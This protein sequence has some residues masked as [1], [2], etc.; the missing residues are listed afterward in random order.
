[1]SGR[2]ELDSVLETIMAAKREELGEPPTPEEL[3]AYRDGELDPAARRSV[4]ARLAVYPDAARALADLA[5]F[6][7]V[8]PAPGTP[9]LS[10][11]EI[12]ARW[13]ALRQKLGPSPGERPSSSVREEP[14]RKEHQAPFRGEASPALKLAA[15]AIL[16][17]GVGILA[18][19]WTRPEPP[20]AS[21]NVAIRELAPVEEAGVRAVSE[22]ELPDASE[23]LVLVLGTP[24]GR[25]FPDYEAEILDA[26]GVLVWSGAG[27]R[28]AELGT[29]HLAFRRG[30]LPPGV[31]QIQISGREGDRKTPL[32]TYDLRLV[33]GPA[34]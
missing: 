19:R 13:Q 23:E 33:G 6:P 32:A 14:S 29:F 34:D 3:L 12:E 22:V 31:Y 4:E 24:A 30:A 21:V 5:A 20:D 18:G 27:L 2:E 11:D 10:D 9:E 17:L 26:E 15:V 7:G 8:E 25:D 1:M 28:P 16:A